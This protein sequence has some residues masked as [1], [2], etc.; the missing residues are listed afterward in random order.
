MSE[1]GLLR[2][3][4]I[5]LFSISRIRGNRPTAYAIAFSL[6]FFAFHLLGFREYTSILSGSL[7]L[8][9]LHHYFGL[10][11]IIFYTCF[12][13]IVP[14]LVLTAIFTGIFTHFFTQKQ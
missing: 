12:V 4:Y 6:M 2:R 8:D 10:I 11:Y 1:M 9:K 5:E 13:V 7:S 3:T 14:I